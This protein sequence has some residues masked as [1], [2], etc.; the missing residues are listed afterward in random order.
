M[1]NEVGHNFEGEEG[2]IIGRVWRE[3]RQGRDAIVP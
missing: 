2:R 1:K 3:G